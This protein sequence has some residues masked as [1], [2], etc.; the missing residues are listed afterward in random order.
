MSTDDDRGGV[1]A[2]VAAA[3]AVAQPRALAFLADDV[4]VEPDR[5]HGP[6]AALRD[7]VEIAQLADAQ[8]HAAGRG[9]D[10]GLAFQIADDLLDAG[11]DEPSYLRFL[12]EEGTR[13]EARRVVDGAMGR[14]EG[15]GEGGALL[16]ALAL[17]CVERVY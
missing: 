5:L 9:E 17:R 2:H 15:F 14:I 1:D 8:G 7:Q 10:L 6:G 4:Q 16:R 12:G 11:E 3:G 13:R